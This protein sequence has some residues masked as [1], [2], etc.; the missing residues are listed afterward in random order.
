LSL[1]TSTN[2]GVHLN[3]NFSSSSARSGILQ[4]KSDLLQEECDK[5]EK[6]NLYIL[7]NVLP[8]LHV[9]LLDHVASE[10]EN[11]ET[12]FLPYI[13]NNLWP[14]TKN[15]TMDLYKNYGLN[16][17][18]ILGKDIHRIF[19]TE[20]DGGNFISLDEAKIFGPKE[21]IIANI[22]VSSGISAVKLDSDKIEQLNEIIESGDP[23][24][25]Y[26]PVSGES[27]CEDLLS[28]ISSI[29]VFKRKDMIVNEQDEYSHDSL[30]KLL[31]FILDDK[32][33]YNMLSGLPLV[34]LSNG[35]VGKFGEVYYVGERAWLDLFPDIG[36]SKFVSVD[37]P[38][39]LSRIFRDDYF[40]EKTKIKIFNASAILDL[41]GNVIK[42]VRE[43]KWT[44]DGECIPNRRW[45]E[46][47]WL[48]LNNDARNIDFDRLSTFPILPKIKPSNTLVRPDIS[49]PLIQNGNSLFS[50][51]DILVKLKVRFTNMTFPESAH[52]DLKKCVSE[53]TAINIINSLEK[54]RSTLTM[55]KLF[56]TSKLSSL[57][58][59]KFRTFIKDELEI[60]IGK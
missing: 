21:V 40:S 46:R 7:N 59:E 43:L 14:N 55:K 13:M 58:Y 37:L 42:P 52:E 48:I 6:R 15:V 28:E 17:V 25:P 57:E 50:L 36:P 20:L 18:K 31:K 44:P 49:N 51:F 39:Y 12:N 29:P 23:E 56:E 26:K 27:V 34:P 5:N 9:K 2:L 11:Q 3:G 41:L 24:F 19:W 35:S 4:S 38:V 45:F 1:S 10:H 32:N 33:S 22:L 53:C 54:V 8:D 60:L 47:I 16:V 30:F